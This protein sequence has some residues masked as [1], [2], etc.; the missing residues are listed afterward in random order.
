MVFAFDIVSYLVHSK[1]RI[2]CSFWNL[3]IVRWLEVE[4]ILY[5]ESF[6]T[7]LIAVYV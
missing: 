3:K 1:L 4:G 7:G 5:A 6:Y 2:N